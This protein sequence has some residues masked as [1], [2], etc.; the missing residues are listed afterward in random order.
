M[1]YALRVLSLMLLVF[2]AGNP[3]QVQASERGSAPDI[4]K[5]VLDN[6][7]TVVIKPEPGSG[8]VA[9]VAMVRAGANQESIQNSGIGLFVSQ[10]LLAGTRMSSAEEVA[11]I[12]DEVGGNI[13]T[14]WDPDFAQVRVVTTTAMFNR[15]T[16]L[17]GEALTGA[18]FEQKWVDQVRADLVRR[19]GTESD[20]IFTNA[21]AELRTLLYDDN[22]YRRPYGCPA[23]TARLA[24]QNDLMK[25]YAAHYVPNNMVISIV[26]DVTPR[27]AMDRVNKAFAGVLRGKLPIDRGVP[28]EKL[29]RDRHRVSEAD[30]P[31]AYLLMGWLAP[32]VT[33]ED[34][35][36]AAVAA[37]ALGRGKGSLMFRELR[38]KRGMGYDVGVIY[39]RHRH[40][41]HIVAYIITDPF[42]NNLGG[43]AA[44]APLLDE[45]KAAL[46]DQV[47][48]L[49]TTRL[50]ETDLE[51]AKGYTIGSY[52]LSHQR[53][54]D[55][56]YEIGW[57]EAVG[58]GCETYA[59]YARLIE[60]VT[61][62][63]VQRIANKCFSNYASV[64]LLPK[65]GPRQPGETTKE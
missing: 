15:A 18:N 45:V 11:A 4:V 46:L 48:F 63:D 22:G 37:T 28:D 5:R 35:P 14:Y 47:N 3:S 61:A 9:V 57:L 23:R 29:L 12:A 19:A 51:R 33:S 55:R 56:A 64:V 25:F 58:V 41:S 16:S 49:K 52:R 38:Q 20:D 10:L 6:G 17:L 62:E 31:A 44:P 8:L 36:A 50:S 60:A 21:Y 59:D 53:L 65:A 39:P 30:I 24:T 26:G 32:G 54:L 2:L 27:Q 34:Y 13:G 40:Q 43:S 1:N 7:L 42:K